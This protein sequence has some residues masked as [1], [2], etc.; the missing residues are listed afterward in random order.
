MDENEDWLKNEKLLG[1]INQT[2]QSQGADDPSVSIG[3]AEN[4]SSQRSFDTIDTSFESILNR[5]S[6]DVVSTLGFEEDPLPLPRANIPIDYEPIGVAD[7]WDLRAKLVHTR[8][9]TRLRID[10]LSSTGFACIDHAQCYLTKDRSDNHGS[11]QVFNLLSGYLGD[12]S[13]RLTDYFSEVFCTLQELMTEHIWMLARKNPNVCRACGLLISV[14]SHGPGGS[15]TCPYKSLAPQALM[16]VFHFSYMAH[17]REHPPAIG[18]VKIFKPD[19]RT[20]M[21]AAADL[22]PGFQICMGMKRLYSGPELCDEK[23]A[24][25]YYLDH[26]LTKPDMTF[27]TPRALW[28]LL[29]V[30]DMIVGQRNFKLFDKEPESAQRSK[31]TTKPRPKDNKSILDC[32]KVVQR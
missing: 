28:E 11:V 2:P 24:V 15:K 31:R 8:L 26:I 30:I 7:D 29:P 5:E 20:Y 10:P 3:F 13:Y 12:P 18:R 17:Y 9:M 23:T 22:W 14:I 21:L 1:Y 32:F 19:E 27:P 4:L 16:M 25:K 6:Q